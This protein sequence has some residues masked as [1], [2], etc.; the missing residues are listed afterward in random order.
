MVGRGR[1]LTVE[2]YLPLPS[3][4]VQGERIATP[5][6]TAMPG[7]PD[8]VREHAPQPYFGVRLLQRLRREAHVLVVKS[9]AVERKTLPRP[10]QLH[11]LQ[12]FLE[13]L[14]P[15]LQGNGEGVV[16]VRVVAR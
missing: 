11:H 15:S 13:A 14:P 9:P 4:L 12:P 10:R 8:G 2:R 1:R 16:I 3:L 6:V 7:P 5:G